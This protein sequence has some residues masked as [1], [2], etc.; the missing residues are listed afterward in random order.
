MARASSPRSTKSRR[1]R[2]AWCCQGQADLESTIAAVNEGRV[3][4][5]LLKPCNSETLFGVIKNGIEQYRLIHAEKHLLE[6]TL[7]AT[8]K[9]LFDV[10]GLINPVGAAPRRADPALRGKRRRGAA[11]CCPA[12][13]STTWRRWSRSSAASRMPQETLARAFGGQPLN[14]EERRLYESHPRD[15]RQAARHDSAPRSRRRHG[16][17]PDAGTRRAI[18][19]AAIRPPGSRRRSAPRSS[20]RRC[21]FDRHVSQGRMPEQAAQLV[22]Q[23]A[24]GLPP[25]DHAGHGQG[26]RG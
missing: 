25:V 4:R 7:N 24:P 11:S 5:F 10:L 12:C 16:R 1:R 14:D 3:F 8:V 17:G 23:A 6:N 2:C 22:N 13:G 21:K 20:G 15:R 9:V 19:P 26:N 18:S